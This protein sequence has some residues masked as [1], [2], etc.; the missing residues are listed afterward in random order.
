MYDLA[1]YQHTTKVAKSADPLDQIIVSLLA[2]V[3]VAL[4]R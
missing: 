4:L 2:Q 1:I 3:Q